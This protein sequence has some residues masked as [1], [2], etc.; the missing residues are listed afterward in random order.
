MHGTYHMVTIE[1]AVREGYAPCTRCMRDALSSERSVTPEV[2]IEER[3]G[4]ARKG[5][6]EGPSGLAKG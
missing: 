1:E 4:G 2:E 6:G 3:A 5:K